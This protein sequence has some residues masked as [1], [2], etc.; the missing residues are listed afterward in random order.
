MFILMWSPTYL[1]PYAQ[2]MTPTLMPI[3]NSLSDKA[4]Q[5]ASSSKGPRPLCVGTICTTHTSFP[6]S[7]TSWKKWAPDSNWTQESFGDPVLDSTSSRLVRFPAKL[8]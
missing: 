2:F 6:D 1:V 4:Y 7:S 5:V 3:D 8:L